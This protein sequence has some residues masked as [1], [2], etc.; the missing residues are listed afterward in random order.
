LRSS[1]SGV[2]LSLFAACVAQ[3]VL[4]SSA[5]P[6]G[7]AIV[8]IS[9]SV[10]FSSSC[11]QLRPIWPAFPYIWE[12]HQTFTGVTYAEGYYFIACSAAGFCGVDYRG[13]DLG[14]Q[15]SEY[16]Q[17]TSPLLALGLPVIT[18]ILGVVC[19]PAYVTVSS[20]SQTK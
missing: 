5:L 15:C 10:A 12:D 4:K 16:A 18:Y 14:F 2:T 6:T 3:K 20:S 8:A 7:T 11:W 1:F 9:L 19:V 13:G 17:N